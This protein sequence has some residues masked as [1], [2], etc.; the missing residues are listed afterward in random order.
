M[1]A[2][3]QPAF[4]R[5][6]LLVVVFLYG[7]MADEPSQLLLIPGWFHC[8]D[9]GRTVARLRKTRR[10]RLCDECYERVV[11]VLPEG[12]IQH[13]SPEQQAIG[14]YWE[15]YDEMERRVPPRKAAGQATRPRPE[16]AS[17]SP[18]RLY[19][20]CECG[21]RR[22]EVTFRRN[23]AGLFGGPFHMECES[24]AL[25]REVS[26]NFEAA[27]TWL[28]TDW[29]DE[30]WLDLLYRTVP[31]AFELG[32]LPDYWYELRRQKE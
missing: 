16:K 9:C 10:F 31:R 26:G 23:E 4:L 2:K 30:E 19:P 12:R 22:Q 25:R 11:P 6:A 8:D 17:L 18:D 14:R 21:G 15:W 28:H 3:P 13:G 24:C 32:I 27:T 20:L 1:A 5:H 29:D 7:A